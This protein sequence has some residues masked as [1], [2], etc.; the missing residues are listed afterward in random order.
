MKIN[1]FTDHILVITLSNAAAQYSIYSDHVAL[2]KW[3]LVNGNKE[4]T[5]NFFM[6][7]EDRVLI[8]GEDHSIQSYPS[9]S[10]SAED[11]TYIQHR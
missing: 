2:R 7:K 3:H 1:S 9:K 6:M 4:I 10:F 11:I 8:Q 5:G